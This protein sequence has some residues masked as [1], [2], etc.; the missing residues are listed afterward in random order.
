MG[1]HFDETGAQCRILTFKEGMLSAIAHDLEIAVTR[2]RVDISDSLSVTAQFATDSLR[3]LNAVRDGH[4]ID[5]LSPADKR[6][7]ERNIADDVLATRTHP[8]ATFAG[9]ATPVAD[10][11]AIE[12][13]LTLKGVSRPLT[14]V[15]RRS[16]QHLVL[17]VELHQPN[18]G[19]RP[20]TA[21]LGTLRVRP[22]VKV[23]LEV[24]EA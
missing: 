11:F 21:M 3:V 24:P 15:A 16:K 10:G 8:Q 17:E 6:K 13:N 19:V 1:K 4:P 9:V 12:G 20:F 14:A 22:E 23:R 2:F 7:I 18:W 5:V